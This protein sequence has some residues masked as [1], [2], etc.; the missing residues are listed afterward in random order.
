MKKI[1]FLIII[2]ILG[3]VYG[4]NLYTKDDVYV[5]I[6]SHDIKEKV[7]QDIVKDRD[8]NKYI[9]WHSS[10]AWAV[11]SP[12]GIKCPWREPYGEYGYFEI[13]GVKLKV[14]RKDLDGRFSTDIPDGKVHSLR[15]SYVYPKMNAASEINIY[16]WLDPKCPKD[17]P[18]WKHNTKGKVVNYN[19]INV[20]IVGGTYLPK[21]CEDEGIC[22]N[23]QSCKTKVYCDSVQADYATKIESWDEEERLRT[24]PELKFIEKEFGMDVY[25]HS[26]SYSDGE[27]SKWPQFF[28]IKG[29]NPFEPKEWMKCNGRGIEDVCAG[30]THS[31]SCETRFHIE[32]KKIQVEYKFATDIFLPKHEELKKLVIEKIKSYVIR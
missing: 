32:D 13:N 7:P 19:L 5:M 1:I 20:Y 10:Q 28:Y 11:F 26:Y 29:D 31:G 18:I 23:Y 25:E 3:S 24:K 14:P 15:L 22:K 30:R 6:P 21:A 16:E 12:Q 4:Y 17:S 9:E 2:I 8:C 27:R